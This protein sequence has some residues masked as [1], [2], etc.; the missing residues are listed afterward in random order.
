MKDLMDLFKASKE[1]VKQLKKSLKTGDWSVIQQ[2]AKHSNNGHRKC[3]I[4]FLRE[5]T[6]NHLKPKTTSGAIGRDFSYQLN[7]IRKALRNSSKPLVVN[8]LKQQQLRSR[9]VC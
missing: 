7:H 6:E 3:R 9:R 8:L 4:S 5:A 2:E 1:S